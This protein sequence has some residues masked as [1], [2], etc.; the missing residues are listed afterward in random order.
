MKSTIRTRL[1]MTILGVL[2][3]YFGWNDLRPRFSSTG[4]QSFRSQT[5]MMKIESRVEKTL[6]KQHLSLSLAAL[7]LK[8]G[9]YS[10]GRDPF[11]YAAEE[12]PEI[13]PDAA[14]EKA[15]Q[16]APKARRPKPKQASPEVGNKPRLPKINLTYLGSFG[17]KQQP[18]A[19]FA[20]GE[21]LINAI[22]G[23][24][25]VDAFIVESIGYE[26]VELKFVDFPNEPAHRLAAGG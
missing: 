6:P 12:K 7:D 23:D 18:I 22:S 15:P 26:S 2:L 9:A 13:E 1:L 16:A 20:Q 21:D 4:R 5:S 24:V 17:M 8:P 19:V 3:A 25:L 11:R 14:Q 10:P